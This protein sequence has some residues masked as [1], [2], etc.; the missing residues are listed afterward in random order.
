MTARAIEFLLL[1]IAGPTW[2]A[3]ARHRI[4]AI[5]A[6]WLLTGYCLFILLRDPAFDRERLWN[7]GGLGQYAPAILGLWAV[8]L[9][10]GIALML[11][12]ARTAFLNWPKTNPLFWSLVMALYP[13]LSVYP[14]GIVYRAFVFDRYSGLFGAGWGMVAASAF[15]FTY[16]HIVFHNRLA[17]LLTFLGGVLFALRYLQTGSLMISSFEHALYGCAVFTIG[18][19]RQFYH[20]AVQRERAALS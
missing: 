1:F 3:Y 2:F 12:Y 14:Q 9:L 16:V 19:G 17:L 5:P 20:S 8:V 4:P 6:L 13:V 10:I 18:I 15:A 7:A 11:R